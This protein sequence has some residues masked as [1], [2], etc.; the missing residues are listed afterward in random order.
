M[1][2]TWLSPSLPLVSKQMS[3]W[4]GLPEPAYI[5]Y[6][7]FLYI[8]CLILLCSLCH[9]LLVCYIL[10]PYLFTVY[11]LPLKSKFY[12]SRNMTCF[13]SLLDST[14]WKTTKDIADTQ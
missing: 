10:F 6:I 1:T 7:H 13:V 4:V 12:E 2:F 11:L 3:P 5:K 9:Y 8:L 14:A